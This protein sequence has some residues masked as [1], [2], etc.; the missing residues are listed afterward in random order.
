VLSSFLLLQLPLTLAQGANHDLVLRYVLPLV[1]LTIAI[2]S[3]L[4][5]LV[6][7]RLA[8][9][10]LPPNQRCSWQAAPFWAS[11]FTIRQLLWRCTKVALSY[12]TLLD[13]APSV[14][15]TFGN[16]RQDEYGKNHCTSVSGMPA[17]AAPTAAR[18]L[19]Q[20]NGPR[21]LCACLQHRVQSGRLYY[22]ES[23]R[24]RCRHELLQVDGLQSGPVLGS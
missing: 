20:K 18:Y 4:I 21:N 11:T 22:R 12:L 10:T 3:F 2:P 17:Q 6:V 1:T 24:K 9:N 14:R 16:E 5:V 8:M 15:L 7:E 13:Y 23:R 19:R